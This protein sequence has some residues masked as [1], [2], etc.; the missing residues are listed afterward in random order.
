ME[1]FTLIEN[2]LSKVPNKL[3]VD[4]IIQFI[5]TKDF[6]SHIFSNNDPNIYPNLLIYPN[7]LIFDNVSD[8]NIILYKGKYYRYDNPRIVYCISE[9]QYIY[10]GYNDEGDNIIELFKC[11]NWYNMFNYYKN[12]IYNKSI[13]LCERCNEKQATCIT[14]LLREYCKDCSDNISDN[15]WNCKYRR[16]TR[17]TIEGI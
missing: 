2:I 13:V 3:V 4:D 9:N 5:K 10:Y 8:D 6:N 14:E 11:E 15:I 16:F 7:D 1:D 12:H 17:F